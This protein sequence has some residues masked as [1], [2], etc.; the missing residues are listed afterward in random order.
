V[1][2]AGGSVD[3]ARAVESRD[4]GQGP[5]LP[6][7]VAHLRQ[8][9]ARGEHV[10]ELNE[11]NWKAISERHRDRPV[12]SQLNAILHFIAARSRP[13]NSS[14]S[15]IETM[16]LCSTSQAIGVAVLL[17]VRCPEHRRGGT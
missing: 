9:K 11:T 15:T 10:A 6:F 5:L 2:L 3:D 14:G 16:V 13:G 4:A 7:L 1:S 12:G 17:R 8:A